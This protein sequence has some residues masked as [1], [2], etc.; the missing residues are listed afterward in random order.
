MILRLLWPPSFLGASGQ[1][2]FRIWLEE[3]FLSL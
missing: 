3:K 1:E 2:E